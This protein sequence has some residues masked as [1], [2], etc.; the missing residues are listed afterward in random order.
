MR[1]KARLYGMSSKYTGSLSH[2]SRPPGTVIPFLSSPP[3]P[4]NSTFLSL[5]VFLPL[6]MTSQDCHWLKSSKY[7]KARDIYILWPLLSV[8]QEEA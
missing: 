8:R 1:Q 3:P 4:P 2:Y 5:P 6:S 7:G